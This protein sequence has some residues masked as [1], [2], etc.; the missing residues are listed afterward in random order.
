MVC[1]SDGIEFPLKMAQLMVVHLAPLMY[2]V[3]RCQAH[4][5]LVVIVDGD[6][7]AVERGG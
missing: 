6:A 3:V 7:N 1:Y 4:S 2:A 5:V